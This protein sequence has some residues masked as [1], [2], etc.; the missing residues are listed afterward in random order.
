[1]ANIKSLA[2]LVN[3]LRK[4]TGTEHEVEA[5]SRLIKHIG[6]NLQFKRAAATKGGGPVGFMRVHGRVIPIRRK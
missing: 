1:M 2:T 6:K 3:R 4:F 5:G